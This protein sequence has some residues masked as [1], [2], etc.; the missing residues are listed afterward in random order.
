MFLLIKYITIILME[1]YYLIFHFFLGV[2]FIL[3][4]DHWQGFLNLYI[5]DSL[6]I[7]RLIFAKDNISTFFNI[8]CEVRR[9]LK[10]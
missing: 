10:V 9:N 1:R 8:I 5:Q 4:R 3:P 6:T 7:F 2:R